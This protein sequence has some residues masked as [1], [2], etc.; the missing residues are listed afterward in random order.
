[1]NRTTKPGDSNPLLQ[2]EENKK[3]EGFVSRRWSSFPVRHKETGHLNVTCLPASP[4]LHEARAPLW[5]VFNWP[6]TAAVYA[7]T[8]HKSR[9]KPDQKRMLNINIRASPT[10]K[11][12][13]I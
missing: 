10:T 6:A 5:S 9:T 3:T 2:P 1:V 7:A 13:I 4:S 11:T 12:Q 8:A